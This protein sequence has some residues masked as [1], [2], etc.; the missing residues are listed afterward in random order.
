[1][2]MRHTHAPG[3]GTRPF[4]GPVRRPHRQRTSQWKGMGGAGLCQVHTPVPCLALHHFLA[5]GYSSKRGH[6]CFWNVGG[7][8]ITQQLLVPV[9]H[10]A[11][12]ISQTRRSTGR[13]LSPGVCHASTRP[14]L[15]PHY[16]PSKLSTVAHGR[17]PSAGRQSAGPWNS[18]AS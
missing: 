9:N 12:S 18:L 13:R 2:T 3:N 4:S 7:E 5:S 11:L 17:N 8:T 6:L 16:S 1:M 15:D 14:E 10:T